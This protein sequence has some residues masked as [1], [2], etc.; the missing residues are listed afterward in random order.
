MRSI[1]LYALCALP[2]VLPAQEARFDLSAR[3]QEL[4]L[5]RTGLR[6]KGELSVKLRA[7]SN[8]RSIVSLRVQRDPSEKPVDIGASL[9][10]RRLLLSALSSIQGR[11]LRVNFA[12][13]PKVREGDVQTFILTATSQGAKAQLKLRVRIAEGT[14]FL[15]LGED[16]LLRPERE[17]K[18]LHGGVGFFRLSLANKG[19]LPGGFSIVGLGSPGFN[20][21]LSKNAAAL[22]AEGRRPLAFEARVEAKKGVPPG[23]RGTVLVRARSLRTGRVHSMSF[24]VENGG[25]LYV[26]SATRK[27][28]PHL[29]RA[30][31]LTTYVA[32]LFPF[33]DGGRKV[34]LAITQ[35][36]PRWQAA[37]TRTQVALD[38]RGGEQQVFVVVQAPP[39]ARAGARGAFVLEMRTDKGEHQRVIL[40]AKVTKLR[41]TYI[42]A[43]DALNEEYLDLDRRGTAQ[44]K[45][46]DWLMPFARALGALGATYDKAACNLPTATDMNHV[47]LLA[48]SK[49][50]TSGVSMVSAFFAG[51]DDL[52]RPIVRGGS[53]DLLRFGPSGKPVQLLF[54]AMQQ[55]DPD[56]MG[57]F[58]SGKGWV[59]ELIEDGGRTLQI[60]AAGDRG[61]DYI[62]LPPR[63]VL[64]DPETDADAALDPPA[65]F[66][67]G[68]LDIG[69]LVGM[70]PTQFPSN[71]YVMDS[72]IRVLLHEDP[73]A[74]YILLATADDV[75]HTMGNASRL[76]QWDN[77]GTTSTYDDQNRVNP[78]A[79]R[80]EVLDEVRD[81]DTQLGR[82]LL[83]LLAKGD[84]LDSYIV[85]SADHGQVTHPLGGIH[86][87]QALR[88]AG[89]STADQSFIYAGT[90]MMTVYDLDPKAAARAE[91]VLEQKALVFNRAEMLSGFDTKTGKPFALHRELFS[92]WWISKDKAKEGVYRWPVLFV[93][94]EGDEQF[95]LSGKGL[96]NLGLP[97]N[98]QLPRVGP[99]VGGHG[100]PA[101]AHIP[102][103]LVGPGVTPGYRTTK[104]VRIHD[105]MPTV[106]Q[107]QGI[108]PPANVDGKVLPLK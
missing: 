17:E 43:M 65:K 9:P 98:L 82:F 79:S 44:G 48:G 47:N 100:G 74:M 93:F 49:T 30:G 45:P 27:A 34:T 5:A 14:P 102:L 3:S 75:Q 69:T 16:P 77:R 97:P 35:K 20:V 103:I 46:G 50:G 101:S 63:Y 76:S 15:K 33:A 37:L 4:Q 42:I 104:A 39:L 6:A 107:L 54:D 106:Y 8:K 24:K 85:L 2:V 67:V 40:T 68:N 99:F 60:S 18:L 83:L 10:L 71:K 88:A 84:L 96:P 87:E 13:G 66:R 21:K 95:A 32:R 78:L 25:H 72:A 41:K 38:A 28:K 52:G 80:E 89:I 105:L 62:G 31:K 59:N 55:I 94:V 91:K 36:T 61:P 57:A 81:L 26:H 29:V 23:A 58:V 73:A 64:G 11:S 7:L 12:A 19:V 70:F 92:P 1:Y 53:R 108:R 86:F 22:P 51:R 90:S 56:A